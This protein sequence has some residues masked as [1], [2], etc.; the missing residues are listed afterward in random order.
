MVKKYAELY[1]NR[2]EVEIKSSTITKWEKQ[3]R[4]IPLL[5]LK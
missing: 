1:C 5:E 2:I 4:F 3:F